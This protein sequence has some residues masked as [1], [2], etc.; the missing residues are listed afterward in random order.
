MIQAGLTFGRQRTYEAEEVA[1]FARL[2]GDTNPLH[3]DPEHSAR[4][5]FGGL[6]VS[7]PQLSAELAALV[8][9]RFS[10]GTDMLGL[11]F[12]FRFLQA[13]PVG[14]PVTMSWRVLK[15]ERKSSGW[16][17]DAHGTIKDEDDQVC[18]EAEGR[19]FVTEAL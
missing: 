13:V 3:S 14:Q 5:R 17:V 18:V 15:A 12:T 7:G 1:N 8:A 10:Q 16:I 11:E 2:V 19:S 9:D 6:I 4:T